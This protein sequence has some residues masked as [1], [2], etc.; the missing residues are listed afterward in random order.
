M[1]VLTKTIST[2]R[3]K[4][5]WAS[6]RAYGPLYLM[7]LPGIVYYLVFRYGPMYGALIAFKDY[8]IFEGIL[9]SPWAGFKHF[10][11]LFGN[12]QFYRI[13]KNTILI[14]TLKLVCSMPMDIILALLL[15]EVRIQSFK[16]IVQTAT[17]L[18]HFLS[19]VMIYGVLIA[20]LAPGAGLFNQWLRSFGFEAIPFLTNRNW[21]LGVLVAT[22]IWKD[23]GWGAII[24]LA[25]LSGVS[26]EL[27]DAAR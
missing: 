24:Y 1:A 18:P 11:V 4:G 19:W 8:N 20:L 22:E 12:P 27:Y 6:L 25:A 17:Y 21:F 13:L 7:M 14:S 23:A 15:N 9:G 16:R 3:R 10:E 2:T 5:F 26:P